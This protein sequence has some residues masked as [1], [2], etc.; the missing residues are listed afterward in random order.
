M[1]TTPTKEKEQM[2]VLVAIMNEKS[3]WKLA[4]EALWYRIPQENAPTMVRD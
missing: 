4:S 2:T 1:N 3:D